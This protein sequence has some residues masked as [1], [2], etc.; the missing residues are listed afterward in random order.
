MPS[1]I[2]ANVWDI[3]FD[4]LCLITT[5]YPNI[6]IRISPPCIFLQG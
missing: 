4:C 5:L 6:D 3:T 2:P 1:V